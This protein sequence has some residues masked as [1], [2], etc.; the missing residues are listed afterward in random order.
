MRN[1]KN[2]TRKEKFQILK[3]KKAAQKSE[4]DGESI[5]A[6]ILIQKIFLNVKFVNGRQ[7]VEWSKNV[8]EMSHSK[9]QLINIWSGT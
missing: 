6:L 1:E 3:G 2:V 9:K 8:V 7:S 4:F 5:S